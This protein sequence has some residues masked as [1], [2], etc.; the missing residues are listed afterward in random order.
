[1]SGLHG[2]WKLLGIE[3]TE[4]SRE[5][6]RAYAVR[7]KTIDVDRDPQ[8]FIALREALEQAQNEARWMAFSREDE[9]K[10]G[11]DDEDSPDGAEDDDATP[12]PFHFDFDDFDRDSLAAEVA[13]APAAP[14]PWGPP[15]DKDYDDRAR[16]LAQLLYEHAEESPDARQA[17][18]MLEH[19]QRIIRDPRMQEM[20]FYADAENWFADLIAR[21]TPFSDPLVTPVSD[22][23]GWMR[24]AGEIGQGPAIAYVV[25]RRQSLLYLD[26]IR[27]PEHRLHAAFV[28]LTR[29]ADERSRR[30]WT[31]RG[32]IRELLA[33]VRTHYP[34]LE[35]SFDPARVALWEPALRKRR[36]NW[37]GTIVIWILIALLHFA[38]SQCQDNGGSIPFHS[39]DGESQLSNERV[40]TDRALEALYQG[41]LDIATVEGRNPELYAALMARWKAASTRKDTLLKY[42][43]DVRLFLNQRLQTSLANASLPLIRDYQQLTLERAKAFST[44]SS[45]LC[46]DF[47]NGKEYDAKKLPQALRDRALK[48]MVRA[49]LEY[50]GGPAPPPGNRTFKI[51]GPLVTEAAKRGGMTREQMG[52]AMRYEGDAAQLCAGRIAF[53]ETLL[54]KPD[55]EVGDI[56]RKM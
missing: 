9:E 45:A 34:E 23:F 15:T 25:R 47:L 19:W 27:H 48:L 13:L 7:L 36:M 31:G 16:A 39:F 4:D 10:E 21:T 35:G 41:D 28:E 2:P 55:S 33:T 17:E 32:K 40:D 22:F 42:T 37:L 24:G 49:L 38:T 56:L 14:N 52:Q 44:Q 54:S 51:P 5:I 30:S 11:E 46:S 12:F 43:E 50:R 3:P 8:A 6:R 29:P 26:D 1:M 18:A 20:S 53:L